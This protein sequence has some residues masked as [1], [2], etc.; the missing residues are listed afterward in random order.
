[1]S[2]Y[3]IIAD[4]ITGSNDTGVQLK[5]RGIE[6]VVTLDAA[7][8]GGQPTSYVL[9]T[10]SRSLAGGEAFDAVS[11]A[12]SKIDMSKFDHVVKKVD[13]TL[14]GP[15]AHEVAA[16]DNACAPG[17][18]VFMPALPD[19]GRTT[20]NGVHMLQGKPITETEIAKDLIAPVR[21]DNLKKLLEAV[22]DEP[23]TH[24][25]LNDVESGGIK[26]DSGRVY[27]FDAVTNAHMR[28]V[29]AA[30]TATG[31]KVLWVGSAGI[32][33]NLVETQATCHPA[34]A[35]VASISETTR[36]QVRFAQT[37][38]VEAVV[39]PTEDVVA[40]VE[41]G[42]QP[43]ETRI[44]AVISEVVGII[45]SKRDIIIVSA[46]TYERA[47]IEKIA[48]AGS[49]RGMSRHDISQI[50]QKY[51]GRIMSGVLERSQVS[52]IFVTGGD[53][54]MGFMN[55]VGASGLR[56]VSEVL[57]GIPLMRIVGGKYDNMKVITKAGAFGQSDAL[58][59]CMRKLKEVN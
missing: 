3:L 57:I 29:V 23:V 45:D 30:V 44:Q 49:A 27:T 15:I 39:V 14:R 2:R 12:V 42:G 54:A 37:K 33:D 4:D 50:V 38:G 32:V 21:E 59:F 56:I 34:A 41:N 43:D 40:A 28:A 11:A 17:L 9:D 51:M 19:L 16:A 55:E 1:M 26:L 48:A 8:V 6:T 20:V 22:Y 25:G 35:L 36:D 5:R 24:I 52:G 58:F 53:T 47:E 46:A 31:K 18:I 13:S 7:S 10:E